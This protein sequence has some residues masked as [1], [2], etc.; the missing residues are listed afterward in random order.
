MAVAVEKFGTVA[1]LVNN[2]GR[3][4]SLRAGRD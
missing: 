4:I 3:P 2:A 1:I